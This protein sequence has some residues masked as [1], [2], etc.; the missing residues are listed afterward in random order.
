MHLRGPMNISQLA[1]YQIPNEALKMQKRNSVP[2]Y[3][4]RRAWRQ[5]ASGGDIDTF[6]RNSDEVLAFDRQ[7]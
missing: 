5:R 7:A 6:L 4:R 1:V 3:N 2:F